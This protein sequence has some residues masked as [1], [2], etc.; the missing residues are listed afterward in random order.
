MKE[1]TRPKPQLEQSKM[2]PARW[3]PSDEM[4]KLLKVNVLGKM[5]E[6]EQELQETMDKQKIEKSNLEAQQELQTQSFRVQLEK[7]MI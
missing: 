6:V 2:W 5:R 3:V 4:K 7:D 1:R